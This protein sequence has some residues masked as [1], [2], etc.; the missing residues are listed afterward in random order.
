MLVLPPLPLAP[1]GQAFREAVI[2]YLVDDGAIAE[3]LTHQLLQW[4]HS[5][6]MLD[7]SVC[8]AA[9]DISGRRQLA[10]CMIRNP[11]N[12]GKMDCREAEGMV[13]YRSKMP[14]SLKRNFQ[15]MPGAGFDF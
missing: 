9:D 2:E 12:L 11:F 8:V 15:L 5:G 4:R 10:C 1:P 6:F 7:A 3:S 14:V 13:I